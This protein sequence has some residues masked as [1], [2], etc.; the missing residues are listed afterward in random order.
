MQSLSNTG[1]GIAVKV[2]PVSTRASTTSVSSL[3]A[4]CS[5]IGCAK[6]LL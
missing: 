4:A 6:V 3:E 5:V 1:D 2:A